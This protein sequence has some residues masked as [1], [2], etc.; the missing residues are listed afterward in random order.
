MKRELVVLGVVILSLGLLSLKYN[1]YSWTEKTRATISTPVLDIELPA[2][3]RHTIAVPPAASWGAAAVGWLLVAVG[4]LAG[5]P[6][7]SAPGRS[8]AG[9]SEGSP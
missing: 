7:R 3:Q 4:V 6:A 1:R 9:P 8:A 2:Q 5:G